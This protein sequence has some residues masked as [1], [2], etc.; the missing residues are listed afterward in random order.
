M[1]QTFSDNEKML[2]EKP[3][4][5]FQFRW[6]SFYS[7]NKQSIVLCCM[8]KG[9]HN[10]TKTLMQHQCPAFEGLWEQLE[11]TKDGYLSQH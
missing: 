8:M 4:K 5:S 10:N 9:S 7:H 11:S 3:L 1:L 2:N 6:F